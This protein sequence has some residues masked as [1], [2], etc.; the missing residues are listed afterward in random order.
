MSVEDEEAYDDRAYPKS[1]PRLTRPPTPPPDD[2][3]F[4]FPG[5]PVALE[6][7]YPPPPEVLPAV[8]LLPKLPCGQRKPIWENDSRIPY[9]LT[10]HIVPA[11]YWRDDPDVELP[12]V[13]QEDASTKEERMKLASEGEGKISSLRAEFEAE[14]LLRAKEGKRRNGKERIAWLVLNR[15]V[16]T[17]ETQKQGLT[18]FCAHANG[19]NKEIWEPTLATLLSSPHIQSSVQEIWAWDAVNHGDSALLNVGNLRTLFHWKNTTRDLAMF[20][21][22]YL[23]TQVAPPGSLPTHLPRVS[24]AETSKRLQYGFYDPSLGKKSRTLVGIGHSFGGCVLTLTSLSSPELNNFYSLLILID[25]VI[26]SPHGIY[27]GAH[28]LAIGALTRRDIWSSRNAAK[29]A[30]LKSPFFRRWDP[31]VLALYVECGLYKESQIKLK[32][33][34]LWEAINFIDT[35]TGSVEAWV[36]LWRGDLSPKDV[37][38]KWIVPGIGETELGPRGP[39]ETRTRVWLRSENAENVR[40]EGAGHLVPHEKPNDLGDLMAKWIGEYF[41]STEKAR[42]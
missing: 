34:P 7:A 25:P 29:E 18:L 14:A 28:P 33:P 13:L 32:M 39:L 15:Y 27:R 12:R 20:L 24:Q 31:R 41:G 30:F 16:R 21:T 6:S 2:E 22:H 35:S 8:H 26:L 5:Q 17:I 4:V 36:R 42:L 11:A 9:S 37:G 40:M 1:H 3:R 38:L 19:F 10:T 23:P